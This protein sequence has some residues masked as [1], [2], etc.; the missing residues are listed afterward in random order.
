MIVTKNEFELLSLYEV[1]ERGIKC[2]KI[3]DGNHEII[4]LNNEYKVIN[5]HMG[6][7]IMEENDI[8]YYIANKL[9]FRF[10]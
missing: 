5:S 2:I 8:P 7:G 10:L 6:L 4:K 1:F 3:I 9:E